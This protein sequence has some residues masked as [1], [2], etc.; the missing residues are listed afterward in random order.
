MSSAAGA[1]RVARPRSGSALAAPE[2]SDSTGGVLGETSEEEIADAAARLGVAGAAL[3]LHASLRSFP[4]LE[5]G[6]AT[7]V[8]GLLST[9]ATV[10]VATMSGTWFGIPAPPDDRPARNAIDYRAADEQAAA[11]SWRGATDV[12]DPSRVEV[13]AWLGA[14][15]AYVAGRPDRV[16]APRSGTFAAVGP[17]ASELV[18]AETEADVFGPLRALRDAEGWVVLAGVGLTSMTMLH[19]AEVEAGRQP[20]IRWMRAPDGAPMRVRV[21]ECSNGFERLA[22]TLA[23]EERRVAVGASRW[24]AYPARAL[25]ALTVDAIRSDPSI[26]RCDDPDCRECPDAIAGGPIDGPP[27]LPDAV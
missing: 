10:L 11:A 15:S 1:A 24:R 18:A 19:L 7:L 21:G 27:P 8:D 14:T 17:L 4:R 13:D 22:P 12:Y 16:R 9:G 20:F 6:P 5:R 23:V 25:L 26:T 2:S 3:C